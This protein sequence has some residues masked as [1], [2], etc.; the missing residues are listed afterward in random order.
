M[1]ACI[2][3]PALQ[4]PRSFTFIQM[5]AVKLLHPHHAGIV[6]QRQEQN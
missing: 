3:V 6:Q 1:L 4:K 2:S 5:D